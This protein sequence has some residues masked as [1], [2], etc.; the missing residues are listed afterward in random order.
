MGRKTQFLN[1]HL[2]DANDVYDVEVDQN[3]N[4]EKID[5]K[6]KELDTGKETAFSKKTGF[7]LDKTD[8]YNLDDTNKLGTARALKRLFDEIVRRIGLINWNS[9]TGKPNFNNS[10]TSN[11]TTE[12]ATPS[13]VK[14]AYDRGS[15]ALAEANKK[16]PKFNKNTAFNKSF[17]TTAGTVLEGDKINQTIGKNYG[18]ILNLSGIKTAGLVYFDRNTKKLFLCKRNNH[19]TSA[20][21]NNYI[22][23]DNNSILERLEK[24]TTYEN[25]INNV[26][27]H[28]KI[29]FGIV[30]VKTD[31]S[32]LVRFKTPFPTRCLSVLVS[33][34][35]TSLVSGTGSSAP[36]ATELRK[37]SF[38]IYND[39]N[40]MDIY[41]IAIGY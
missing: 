16:E 14:A 19:D 31:S 1:L 11:S 2:A 17:G 3:Q 27:E 15:T 30:N 33:G 39:H 13:S 29:K 26:D 38:K 8:E 7:N 24:L 20:N 41:W 10:V 35:N 6:L 25:N 23:L 18:G 12:F 36:S 34:S 9:L 28:L 22:A 5:K 21:V 37:E 32:L 4:F 40:Q